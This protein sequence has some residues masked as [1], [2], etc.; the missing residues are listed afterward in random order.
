LN[1]NSNVG[2]AGELVQVIDFNN[3]LKVNESE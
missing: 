2:E 1:I 3:A